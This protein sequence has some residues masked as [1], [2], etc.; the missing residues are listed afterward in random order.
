MR[1]RATPNS[2]NGLPH[3]YRQQ[4]L[5]FRRPAVE[6]IF[7][8]DRAS[9]LAPKFTHANI[10]SNIPY[11]YLYEYLSQKEDKLQCRNIH[12]CLRQSCVNRRLLRSFSQMLRWPFRMW[13]R[14]GQG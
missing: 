2:K 11:L 10:N 8:S 12:A 9:Q 14:V 4:Q 7:F 5:L 1:L 13:L 6:T 3:V